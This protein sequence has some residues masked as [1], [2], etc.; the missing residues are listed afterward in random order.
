MILTYSKIATSTLLQLSL[1]LPQTRS[2]STLEEV[3]RCDVLEV[4]VVD[5]YKY[6]NLI[7]Q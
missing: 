5:F 7:V 6:S 2:V 3:I 4:S 1:I